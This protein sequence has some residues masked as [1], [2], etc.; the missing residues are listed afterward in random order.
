M[1][2]AFVAIHDLSSDANFVFVSGSAELMLGYKTE[3]IRGRSYFNYMHPDDS[4]T[5]REVW[6]HGLQTNGIAMSYRARL[7]GTRWWCAP[8]FVV[9]KNPVLDELTKFEK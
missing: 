4:T 1:E 3:D 7:Q 2:L 9:V 6:S 8:T 5:V